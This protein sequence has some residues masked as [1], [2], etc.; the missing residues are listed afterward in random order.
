MESTFRCRMILICRDLL[1]Q[2]M[3]NK[4]LQRSELEMCERVYRGFCKSKSAMEEVRKEF[5]EKEPAIHLVIDQE[6]AN[7][8][9]YDLKDMHGYLDEFFTILKDDNRFDDNILSQCRAK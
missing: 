8:G 3:H 5:L 1:M 6:S 9:K 4:M 7:L 2:A